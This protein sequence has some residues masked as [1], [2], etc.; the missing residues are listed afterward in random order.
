MSLSYFT[1]FMTLSSLR[2]FRYAVDDDH[3]RAPSTVRPLTYLD[4]PQR[5][6]PY[7]HLIHQK[8]RLFPRRKVP[9][10]V[11]LVV[12]DEVGIRPLGPAARGLILLVRKNAYRNRD[13]DV[14]GAK[15]DLREPLPIKTPRRDCCVRQPEQRDVVE[16]IV[17][18]MPVGSPS[19]ARAM[20]RK[21][22]G[23]WSSSQAATPMGE[24]AM[25]YSVCGCD[26]MK[27]C[28]GMVLY[29]TTTVSYARFSSA[30]RPVGAGLPAAAA[31]LIS[32]GITLGR[33][34]CIPINSGCPCVAITSLIIA[35]QSPPCATY[36]VYPR[37]FI[38]TAQA[39][40][41]RAWS[42]PVV[43]GLPENP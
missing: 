23:S 14:L 7:A 24:S 27:S 3:L 15:V 29:K 37:R 9:A 18:G 19:K 4:L 28:V 8:L 39:R 42:Q 10:L 5:L 36:R 6:E 2:R 43:V 11:E 33:F 17:P 26:A 21:L 40:A 25:P 31:L 22:T 38:S 12:V 1:V 41:M 30:E 13:G 16:H 34:V 32:G 35:P 20:S